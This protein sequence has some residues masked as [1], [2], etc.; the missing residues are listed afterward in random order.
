VKHSC[1]TPEAWLS[2][3]PSNETWAATTSC[4]ACQRVIASTRQIVAAMQRVDSVLPDIRRER[5][6]Q[7]M[8]SQLAAIAAQLGG[9][10]DSSTENAKTPLST[11]RF[12]RWL[13]PAT[14]AVVALI[15]LWWPTSTSPSLVGLNQGVACLTPYRSDNANALPRTKAYVGGRFSRLVTGNDDVLHAN[16]AGGLIDVVLIDAT[17]IDVRA[18]ASNAIDLE[19]SSGFLVVENRGSATLNIRIG[20]RTIAA[21]LARFAMYRSDDSTVIAVQY[22][23]VSVTQQASDPIS[24]DSNQQWPSD[25]DAHRLVELHGLWRWLHALSTQTAAVDESPRVAPSPTVVTVSSPKQ[26]QASKRLAAE[27]LH[28]MAAIPRRE[29]PPTMPTLQTAADLYRSAE[30]ALAAGDTTTASRTW[31]ALLA[32]FPADDRVPTALF[33]LATVARGTGDLKAAATWLQ[34]IPASAPAS[35]RSNAAYLLCRIDIEGNQLE[36]AADCLQAYRRLFAQSAH[37]Q[38]VLQWLVGY[39]SNHSACSMTRSLAQEYVRR[40]ASS[41]FAEQA[42][43]LLTCGDTP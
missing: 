19:L 1:K 22:G 15:A 35:I 42:R 4:I 17:E 11:W 14:L 32:Q 9:R 27:P 21:S 25:D 26:E 3:D 34:K 2:A 5:N 8:R 18:V 36:S 30:A 28:P 29:Q 37:D 31:A 20:T 39:H 24:V 38:E 13:V 6:A 7:K 10:I 41:K 40:Y 12:A 16:V 23:T 33:D 43:G